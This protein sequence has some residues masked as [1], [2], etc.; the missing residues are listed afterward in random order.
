MASFFSLW[1]IL[2]FFTL[3]AAHTCSLV[4]AQASPL[5]T[6]VSAISAAPAASSEEAP[7]LSPE[8]EPLFPTPSGVAS[9]PSQS[10][11]PTIPSS[12]SPPS[13]KVLGTPGLYWLFHHWPPCLLLPKRHL[14]L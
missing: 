7:M 4:L 11:L 5:S 10:S 2:L 14:S 12:P 9:S 1:S 6:H 13:P 3:M 8:I